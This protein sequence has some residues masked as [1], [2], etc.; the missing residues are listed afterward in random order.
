MR[1]KLRMCTQQAIVALLLCGTATVL[2][3]EAHPDWANA[4][5]PKGEPGPE[6]TLA[7]GGQTDYVI[8]VPA[9]P[10][11]RDQKAGEDLATHLQQMHG[12]DQSGAHLRVPAH[13]AP[14]AFRLLV[15][16]RP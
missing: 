14:S 10:T 11:P 16:L 6:L 12:T 8:L 9:A 4:L 3:A 7:T 5:Q 13:A 15:A 1:W 2:G